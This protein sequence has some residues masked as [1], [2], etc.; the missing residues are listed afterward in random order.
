MSLVVTN[1][2][3]VQAVMSDVAL[4]STTSCPACA[5]CGIVMQPGFTR[6]APRRGFTVKK[7]STDPT[8]A[9]GFRV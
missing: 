7:P 2:K 1:H 8:G 9:P 6:Q 5:L 4:A 3:G